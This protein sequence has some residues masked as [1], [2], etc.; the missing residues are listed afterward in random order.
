M[1]TNNML[2][3]K[4]GPVGHIIFDNPARLNAVYGAMWVTVAEILEDFQNDNDIRVVVVSGAGG[5]AFMS[6]R[7][8][9]KLAE[10]GETPE[11][12]ELY[13]S[14]SNRAQKLLLNMPK[15][16]IAMI[17]GYCIGGG[18]SL[19]LKC[20][21]RISS[22]KSSFA[23]TASKL[24]VGYD[25]DG[26][27][28]LVA[29]I[30]PSFAKEL[31]Y[32]ARQFSAQEEYVQKYAENIA[33]NAPLTMQAVKQSV[34]EDLKDPDDRDVALCDRLVDICNSS[35]DYTE[36]RRAFMEKRQPVFNGR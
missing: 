33:A 3:E 9:T 34:L 36:G 12:Q 29:H 13:N 16:T 27:S 25:Y 10:E 24:G 11:A 35:E 28:R 30:G 2:S 23:I 1:N 26:I 7:D 15:P 5:R 19:G 18:I 14:R 32:T 20:D 4:R 6:G 17:R 31:F 8:I 21:T 22:E